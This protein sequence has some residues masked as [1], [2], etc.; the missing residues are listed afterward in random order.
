MKQVRPEIRDKEMD[1][2]LLDP[3]ITQTP[4]SNIKSKSKILLK[5][6]S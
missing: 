2:L 6:F 5:A 4:K 1:K 3:E